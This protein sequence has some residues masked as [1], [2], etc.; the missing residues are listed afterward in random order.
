MIENALRFLGTDP[1][2]LG[3]A[4]I[5]GIVGFI[6]TIVVAIKTANINKV[7]KY[8]R[9]TEQYNDDRMSF[10]RSFDGYKTTIIVDKLKTENLLKDILTKVESYR[11]NFDEIISIREKITLNLFIRILKKDFNEIDE[12]DW[13]KIC[14]YL[15]KL[16]GRLTK[17][18]EQKN[19]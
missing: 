17:K 13:N 8:N 9:I 18:E 6:L 4:T 1:I 15:A 2:V 16:S 11:A 12:S 14:N 7:L 10:Q 3:I 5:S 19:V